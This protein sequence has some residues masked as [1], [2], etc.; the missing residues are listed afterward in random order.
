[1]K[2]RRTDNKATNQGRQNLL[3]ERVSYATADAVENLLC[4]TDGQHT[5][6]AQATTDDADDKA[7]SNH[8]VLVT[9]G[10]IPLKR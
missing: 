7:S 2:T 5:H 1:M 8:P 4:Y 9:L 3:K 10:F 6:K